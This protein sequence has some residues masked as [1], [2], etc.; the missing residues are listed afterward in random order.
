MVIDSDAESSEYEGIED[1]TGI[2]PPGAIPPAMGAVNPPRQA[3][4]SAADRR[5]EQQWR[6]DRM[7]WATPRRKKSWKEMC[8]IIGVGAVVLCLAALFLRPHSD[9]KSEHHFYKQDALGCNVYVTHGSYS[10]VSPIINYVTSWGCM[11]FMGNPSDEI[12]SLIRTIETLVESKPRGF[13]SITEIKTVA[14]KDGK[15]KYLPLEEFYELADTETPVLFKNMAGDFFG[16]GMPPWDIPFIREI[17]GKKAAKVFSY[18]KSHSATH[19]GGMIPW[20]G[21]LALNTVLD[22]VFNSSR[23]PTA[24]GVPYLHDWT[25]PTQCSE[26]L[27]EGLTIPQYFANDYLQLLDHSSPYRDEWPS[28]FVG[29][30]HSQTGVHVDNLGSHAWL[31]LLSGKKHWRTVRSNFSSLMYSTAHSFELDLFDADFEK[32]KMASLIDVEEVIQ[33][34]GDVIF[35]PGAMLHQ[36]Y[37]L[38]DSVAITSNYIDATGLPNTMKAL[39]EVA[40]HDERV[41]YFLRQLERTKAAGKLPL[42]ANSSLPWAEFKAQR[43]KA[44]PKIAIFEEEHGMIYLLIALT[45]VLLLVVG[46]SWCL[47]QDLAPGC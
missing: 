17:C 33:E 1:N 20:K 43:A 44:A 41:Y 26:I 9:D 28:L 4:V 15:E 10:V 8:T 35:V 7:Q 40:T 31:L 19:W 38:E 32:Y 36:V 27:D 22:M 23:S 6:R 21:K 2:A 14:R 13:A 37:N 39:K 30:K 18:N 11:I 3:K 34:P 12:A 5:R 29:P 46:A 42:K 24:D 25:L 47:Y 45:A 16:D